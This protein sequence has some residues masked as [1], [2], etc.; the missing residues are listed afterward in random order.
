MHAGPSHHATTVPSQMPVQGPDPR[1]PN[2]Q[3]RP[4]THSPN[5]SSTAL[6]AFR[7]WP[8]AERFLIPEL[9]RLLNQVGKLQVT[10]CGGGG[11]LKPIHCVVIWQRL[12]KLEGRLPAAQKSKSRIYATKIRFHHMKLLFLEVTRGHLLAT[13]YDSSQHIHTRVLNDTQTRRFTTARSLL[14]KGRS[15]PMPEISINGM[16]RKCYAAIEKKTGE[17][18][19]VLKYREVPP[20]T[21]PREQKQTAVCIVPF[22]LY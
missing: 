9:S 4:A 6:W 2:P 5:V 15:A 8:E 19:S 14:A 20:A 3:H 12:T 11:R 17:I 18:F 1:G 10:C 16:A 7:M 22:L 13:S 21:L